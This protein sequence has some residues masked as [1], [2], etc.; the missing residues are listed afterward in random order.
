MPNGGSYVKNPGYD[1]N[2]IEQYSTVQAY[3]ISGNSG[4]IPSGA[5]IVQGIYYMWNDQGFTGNGWMRDVSGGPT[6]MYPYFKSDD[7]VEKH[8]EDYGDLNA[9]FAHWAGI[10]DKEGWH[11][12]YMAVYSGNPDCLDVVQSAAQ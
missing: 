10:Y 12:F 7:D 2:E 9:V 11:N 5:S 8:I 4:T 6:N 3:T 1:P